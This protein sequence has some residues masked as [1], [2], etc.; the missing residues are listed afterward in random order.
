MIQFSVGAEPIATYITWGRNKTV[1]GAP[2]VSFFADRLIYTTLIRNRRALKST[3]VEI[4]S[5][6]SYLFI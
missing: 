3:V 4:R 1:I 6:I 5:R 2:N